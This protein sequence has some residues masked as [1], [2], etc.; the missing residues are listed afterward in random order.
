LI[1]CPIVTATKENPNLST[2]FGYLEQIR[3]G[4][5][6]LVGNEAYRKFLKVDKDSI[7]RVQIF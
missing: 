3:K 7:H 4:P 6:A 5:K 1:V 2:I